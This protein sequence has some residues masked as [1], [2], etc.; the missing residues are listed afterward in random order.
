MGGTQAAKVLSQVKVEQRRKD[1]RGMSP[2]EIEDMEAPILDRY[3]KE[4]SPYFSTAR[5]WDD[6]IIS[7]LETRHILSLSLE[8]VQHGAWSHGN[9]FG[10]F[11][12]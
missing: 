11:R 2:R 10:L 4:G 5:L 12:M 3:D 7:P 1:G 9:G 8:A 6:G